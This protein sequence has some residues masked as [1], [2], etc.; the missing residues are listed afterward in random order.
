MARADKNG[1]KSTRHARNIAYQRAL[2]ERK[3]LRKE[4]AARYPRTAPP[5]VVLSLLD[6]RADLEGLTVGPLR[7]LAKSKD[8][9][10][11]RSWRKG[12]IIDAILATP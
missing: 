4:R 8:I 9:Q 1:R 5:I 12:D 7:D 3:R 10:V 11:K 2:K 6:L